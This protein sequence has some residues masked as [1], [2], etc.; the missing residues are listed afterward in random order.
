MS[1]EG[2][3][4]QK[5]YKFTTLNFLYIIS[6]PTLKIRNW[7]LKWVYIPDVPSFLLLWNILVKSNLGEKMTYNSGSQSISKGT[8]GRNLKAACHY[9]QHY[10]W[11]RNLLQSQRI[12]EWRIGEA[13]WKILLPEWPWDFFS[14]LTFLYSLGSPI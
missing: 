8:E 11:V 1:G 2:L 7:N 6:T 13:L 5:Y 12:T 3:V 14:H 9:K 4:S 10:P